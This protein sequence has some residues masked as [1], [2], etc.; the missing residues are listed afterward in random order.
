MGNQFEV[1]TK[2]SKSVLRYSEVIAR[3]Y[4][5]NTIE[6]EDILLALWED[7]QSIAG[8]VL[9]TVGVTHD[10]VL[11]LLDAIQTDSNSQ[12]ITL[13]VS[14]KK[15][16][17]CMIDETRRRG[18][19]R[20]LGTGHL[21]LGIASYDSR[22]QTNVFNRLQVSHTS[23]I[24]SIEQILIPFGGKP[25]TLVNLVW[26]SLKQLPKRLLGVEIIDNW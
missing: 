23:I 19:G 9:R 14:V 15:S 13:S 12:E 20:F 4:K 17:E 11:K 8:R 16:L 5:R 6:I 26:N 25:Q 1:F 24:K 21:L 3:S 10:N 18:L 7:H 2:R 22:H